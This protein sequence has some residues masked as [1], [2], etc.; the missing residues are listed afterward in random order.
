M[1][2]KILLKIEESKNILIVSHK[3]PDGDTLGAG[4]GLAISLLL[5]NKNVVAYCAS[6]IPFEYEFLLKDK[7]NFF[8]SIEDIDKLLFQLAIFVDC[9]DERRTSHFDKISEISEFII[10]IDHHKTNTGFGD[11]NLVEPKASSTGEIIFKLLD[12]GKLP[13]NRDVAE[14]LYTALLTDTGS[15]RYSNTTGDTFAT[16]SALL[17]YGINTWEIAEKVYENKP[18]KRIYIMKEA[19]DSLI[20]SKNKK[21]AV[22]LLK[23][24]VLRKYNAS[25][26][27][28]DGI[29][30]IGRSIAGVEFSI[31]IREENNGC[32]ISFRSRG[33]IDVAK[34]AQKLGGGG[35]KNAAGAFLKKPL[36]IAMEKITKLIGEYGL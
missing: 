9:A 6:K 4:L 24:D 1:I 10:N 23:N 16:A 12:R 30:N 19:L 14:C 15:F 26:E 28:T 3:N 18:L 8:N 5:Q 35:H 2:D 7:I 25:S 22:M 27:D 11:I 34:F 20:I 17:N 36:N 32:K 31:F 21:V 33:N 13:I 29:V